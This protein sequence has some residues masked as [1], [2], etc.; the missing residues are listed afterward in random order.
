MEENVTGLMPRRRRKP[1]GP[2]IVAAGFGFCIAAGCATPP[3]PHAE[4]LSRIFMLRDRR[5]GGNGYLVQMLAFPNV[6]VRRQA[7]LALGAVGSVDGVSPLIRVVKEDQ[8][9]QVRTAAAFALGNLRGPDR[10]TALGELMD[11]GHDEVREAVV[12]SVRATDLGCWQKL[13]DGLQDKD[14]VVRGNVALALLRICGSRRSGANKA[15]SPERRRLATTLLTT[16]LSRESAPEAHWR[17][18]YALAN[19]APEDS[20][21][22]EA[23]LSVL[24]AVAGSKDCHRWSRLF[25][26]RALRWHPATP[27]LRGLLLK[28]LKNRDW[29]LVHEAMDVLA[30]PDPKV[31]VEAGKDPPPRY[32]DIRVV[33]ELILLRRNR[34]PVLRDEAT[35]LLG[36]YEDQRRLV[37]GNLR[38]E[39]STDPGMQ[40]ATLQAL[41]RLVGIAAVPDIDA[42]MRDRDFRVK[43]GAARALALLPEAVAMPRLRDLLWDRDM[44]VRTA[45][46]E[47]LANFRHSD[48]ALGLALDV[49]KVRDLALRETIPNT[50]VGI[51]DPK[52][53]PSLIA[54]YKDSPGLDYAEA[55]KLTVAAVG[56]L[57]GSD[58][59]TVAF[60]KAGAE[61]QNGVV[62]REAAKQLRRRGLAAPDTKDLDVA[63]RARWITPSLGEDIPW[64]L[65]RTRPRLFCQTEEG[66]FILQ[67]YPEYAPVHCHNLLKLVESGEYTGRAFHRV[68]PGFVVQGGDARGDG[69]GANPVFGGQLRDEITPVAFTAGVL[70]MPKTGD[71]DT[72]GDQIFITT[73]PAPHLDRRY[74]AF[75]R[76]VQGMDVVERIRVGDHLKGISRMSN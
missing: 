21:H 28:L 41:T 55:R 10:G 31:I 8:E 70:G 27:S 23:I 29:A 64:T 19:L 26:V 76:V 72:G 30:A 60:L 46:L 50:F 16:A 44:R 33:T 63:E 24:M 32:Q 62:R 58:E 51:G 37:V 38:H 12:S 34:H 14:P 71:T 13:V 25:S 35:L 39:K 45:A 17:I 47:S 57:G 54:A 6:V 1:G 73:V 52:A 48:S 56:K 53:V 43:L 66:N 5:D 3:P 9:L 40:A 49:A 11:D 74:T 18:V 69:F 61:D 75:G 36:R 68:V 4:E 65:L 59:E 67:L 2:G 22:S 42:V 20:D 15:L 7:A